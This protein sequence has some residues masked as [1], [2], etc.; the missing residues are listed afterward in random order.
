MT[1]AKWLKWERIFI[2]TASSLGVTLVN[3]LLCCITWQKGLKGYYSID[4][5]LGRL[6]RNMGVGPMLSDESFKAEN[7][8]R[9]GSQ[10]DSNM[11]TPHTPLL[12]WRWK[13]HVRIAGCLWKLR[14]SKMGTSAPQA[15]EF[16]HQ[17]EW[18][19]KKILSQIKSWQLTPWLQ[20]RGTLSR[21]PNPI[22]PVY[23]P[24]ELW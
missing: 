19:W 14:G 2:P 13:G 16:C 7:R 9:R 22:V 10:C 21:E 4:L 11:R 1:L 3:I 8:S 23:W 24:T 18:A 15:T 12:S 17:P 5:K 20:L 6:S